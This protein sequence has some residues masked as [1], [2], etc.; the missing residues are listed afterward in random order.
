[1]VMNRGR[2]L[3]MPSEYIHKRQDELCYVLQNITVL[4]KLYAAQ[5]KSRVVIKYI[6][7][8]H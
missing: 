6:Y 7:M 1:M 2:N 5:S 8:G 4:T 3:C